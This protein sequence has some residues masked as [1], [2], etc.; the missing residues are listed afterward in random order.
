G[1]CSAATWNAATAY[2]GGQR[3]SY[4][5]S[6]YEAKWWTQGDRP[7]LSG[8][9][10]VWKYISVCGTATSTPTATVAPTVTPTLTPTVAPTPTATVTPAPTVAPTP[11][12]TVTPTQT[13]LPTATPTSGGSSW[14]TGVAYKV[15]DVVAYSGKTYSCLQPHTSLQGWEP[16]STPALW[17]LI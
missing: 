13:P 4:S 3:V 16:A 10:G 11:T 17:K 2:T 7:D 1:Q 5:G 8:P 14:V 9:D 6:L 15:G 12:A